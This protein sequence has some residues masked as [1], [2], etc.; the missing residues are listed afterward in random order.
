MREIQNIAGFSLGQ[1]GNKS[2]KQMKEAFPV[3]NYDNN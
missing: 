1:Y 2:M 3:Q